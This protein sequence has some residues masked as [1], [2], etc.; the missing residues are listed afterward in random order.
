MPAN[1]RMRC[2]VE[3][4]PKRSRL[5]ERGLARLPNVP[6]G[7]QARSDQ[8]RLGS[9][10]RSCFVEL[11][12]GGDGTVVCSSAAAEFGYFTLVGLYY[13]VLPHFMLLVGRRVGFVGI[14]QSKFFSSQANGIF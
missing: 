2:R 14:S 7:S 10:E 6:I 8:S 1:S 9:R 11:L 13:G 3:L 4:R 12:L 5:E